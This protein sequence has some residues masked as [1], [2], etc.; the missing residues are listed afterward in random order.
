MQCTE[1]F[2]SETWRR[3]LLMQ[4]QDYND[5]FTLA[6]HKDVREGIIKDKF[7]LMV[8]NLTRFDRFQVKSVFCHELMAQAYLLVV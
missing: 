4:R 7:V 5:A 2:E 1:H 3:L 8:E 6:I